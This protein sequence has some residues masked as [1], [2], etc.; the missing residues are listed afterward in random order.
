MAYGEMEALS[1]NGWRAS[2]V[3]G[4]ATFLGTLAP[5][6]PVLLAG[7]AIGI[8]GT[9]LLAILV[10]LGAGYANGGRRHR[11]RPFAFALLGLALVA[12]PT[13]I[14]GVLCGGA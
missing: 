7:G 11:L 12:I 4:L 2:G 5:C 3:M 9:A 13:I 8:A 6:L 14:V 10:A 1:S